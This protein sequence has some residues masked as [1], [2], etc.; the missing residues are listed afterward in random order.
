MDFESLDFAEL[1]GPGY[2]KHVALDVQD[3]A[4]SP[5]LHMVVDSLYVQGYDIPSVGSGK[6][7][8]ESLVAR[9]D[10]YEESAHLD[11]ADFDTVFDWGWRS[12]AAPKLGADWPFDLDSL[13][14][15]RSSV[16]DIDH[17][18]GVDLCSHCSFAVKVSGTDDHVCMKLVY[19]VSTLLFFE[20]SFW[21]QLR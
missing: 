11:A 19:A 10:S 21:R 9:Q 20:D 13:A 18:L 8:F 17:G 5:A 1:C 3:N 16:V 6:A 14:G 12:L 15:S 4:G 2:G 7:D